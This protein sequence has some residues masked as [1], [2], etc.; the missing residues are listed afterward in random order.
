M[1]DLRKLPNGGEIDGRLVLFDEISS[2]RYLRAT[3][4]YIGTINEKVAQD[5]LWIYLEG[6][7]KPIK[8]EIR[9]YVVIPFYT[10]R[11]SSAKREILEDFH[12]HLMKN[13][14]SSIFLKYI[15]QLGSERGL[16]YDNVVIFE[17]GDIHYPDGKA[18]LLIDRGQCT[19]LY[20]TIQIKTSS[21]QSIT[22][23]L[24]RLL[25][26]NINLT[27]DVTRD[28]EVFMAILK[29]KFNLYW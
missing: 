24:K 12:I 22:T 29:Q 11:K 23:N 26:E 1:Q 8:I 21:K 19:Y 4:Q 9:S 3:T 20:P 10:E 28:T 14:F 25:T 18:N 17:N 27:I 5:E 6:A 7:Y 2:I 15:E 16:K 13:T